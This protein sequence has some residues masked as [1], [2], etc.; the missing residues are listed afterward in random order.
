MID[1]DYDDD[2][3]TLVFVTAMI[4]VFIVAFAII[5]PLI[6]DYTYHYDEIGAI[7][8]INPN[9][10]SFKLDSDSYSNSCSNVNVTT[11][12][13]NEIVHYTQTY[14]NYKILGII[15]SPFQEICSLTVIQQWAG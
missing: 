15:S 12:H 3:F 13:I 14:Y 7:T 10:N 4:V 2:Y 8:A 11:L 5:M 1:D 6:I 9:S